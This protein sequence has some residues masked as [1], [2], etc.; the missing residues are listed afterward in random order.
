MERGCPI[1]GMGARDPRACECG[2]LTWSD[3]GEGKRTFPSVV[4]SG[5]ECYICGRSKKDLAKF[6]TSP[7]LKGIYST[8]LKEKITKLEAKI[9]RLE[10]LSKGKDLSM[11]IETARR[12]PAVARLVP[13]IGEILEILKREEAWDYNSM[14]ENSRYRSVQAAVTSWVTKWKRWLEAYKRLEKTIRKLKEPTKWQAGLVE[15]TIEFEISDML[16]REHNRG[17]YGEL[18]PAGPLVL[19]TKVL[20]S[21]NSSLVVKV[22]LCTLCNKMLSDASAAAFRVSSDDE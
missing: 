19:L 21:V 17:G 15:T 14:E 3:K 13:G 2:T 1:C 5:N 10:K 7:S 22:S 20:G 16:P 9:K 12:D 11:R 18:D 4:L 8:R 6:Q